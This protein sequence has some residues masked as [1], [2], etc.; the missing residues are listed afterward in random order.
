MV[1]APLS[2]L[3]ILLKGKFYLIGINITKYSYYFKSDLDFFKLQEWSAAFLR[4]NTAKTKD[5]A[6]N[7]LS[8]ISFGSRSI[9]WILSSV[10]ELK[11]FRI[12][13]ERI[14]LTYNTVEKIRNDY[15]FVMTKTKTIGSL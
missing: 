9:E 2:S 13:K 3:Q 12:E 14:F 5:S 7:C 6:G 15:Q 10:L 8:G 11:E 1:F 4:W